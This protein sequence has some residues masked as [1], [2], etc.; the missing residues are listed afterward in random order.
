MKDN[1]D[2]SYDAIKKPK[3]ESQKRFKLGYFPHGTMVAIG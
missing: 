1:D 3:I 2:S